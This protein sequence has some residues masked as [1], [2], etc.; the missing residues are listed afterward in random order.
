MIVLEAILNRL[1]GTGDVLR[2]DN[3]AITGIM[4]YALY[5]LDDCS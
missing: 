3:F 5:F 4:L 2:V 1:R